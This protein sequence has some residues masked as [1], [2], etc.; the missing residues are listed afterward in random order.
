MHLRGRLANQIAI[1]I[2]RTEKAFFVTPEM[3]FHPLKRIDGDKERIFDR[4]VIPPKTYSLPGSVITSTVIWKFQGH[5]YPSVQIGKADSLAKVWMPSTNER[6]LRKPNGYLPLSLSKI[7]Q[8]CRQNGQHLL[9][10]GAP[11]KLLKIACHGDFDLGDLS[12]S[13]S[14][15]AV[16]A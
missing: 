7:A 9:V 4:G 5:R 2:E 12:H 10:S 6:L 8:I 14:C 11:R 13:L 3:R 16:S 1:C 15:A